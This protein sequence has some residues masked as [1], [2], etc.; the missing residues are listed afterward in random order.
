MQA[1]RFKEYIDL[2]PVL[3]HLDFQITQFHFEL[4]QELSKKTKNF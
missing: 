1:Y 3:Q 4:F 2:I